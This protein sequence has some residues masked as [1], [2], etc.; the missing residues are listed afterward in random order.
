MTAREIGSIHPRAIPKIVEAIDRCHGTSLENHLHKYILEPLRS[1]NHPQPLII[2]IDAM[3]EWRDHPTFINAL[4]HLN[5]QSHVVKFIITDRLNPC[6]SRLPGI[7]KISIYTYALGP[8]SKQV[9]KAYFHKHLETVPWVDGRTATL[10]D[11][12]KLTELSG[13]LPVW[14]STVIALLSHRFSESPP[15]EVL[16]DIVGSRRQVGGSDGLGELYRKAL[17]RLFPSPE[18][19]RQLLRYLAATIVLQEPLSPFDFSMLSGIPS[20]LINHIQ[21]ALT[22]LQTR[23][24]PLG[25]EEMV[26]PA[27]TLFHQSFLDYVQSTVTGNSFLTSAVDAHSTLGL[28]CLRQLPSLPSSHH[29]SYLRD[30]QGYAVKYWPFHVSKGTP[31]ANDQ[32]SQTEHC[33]TILELTLEVQQRWA[34]LFLESFMPEEMD[35]ITENVGPEDSMVLILTALFDRLRESGEDC[36]VF[37]VAC[38]EVAVRID[39]GDAMVWSHLGNCYKAIG[40]RTGSLHMY[41]EA[42]V[43]FRHALRLQADVHPGRAES[44]HNVANALMCCY[45]QN[46]HR[47]ILNEAISNC[48]E[49]LALRPAPH[50]DRSVSLNNLANAL[51]YL[52]ERDGGIET[53]NNVISLNREALE[54]RPTPHPDRATSLSNLA[55]ALQSLYEC[56]GG[57]RTLNEVVSL[58]REALALRP[59]PHPHRSM[60]LSNLAGALQSLYECDGST[61]TLNEVISRSREALA[62]CPAPHPHRSGLLNTLANALRSLYSQ[63]G[64]VNTLNESVSLHR[65]ALALHPP[66]HP[67]R[68]MSLNNLAFALHSLHECSGGIGTLNEVISLNRE[69]LALCPTPHPYRPM[70]LNNLANA[71]QSLYEC[72]GGIK[73]LSE[74]ISLHR[75]AL[76]LRPAPHPDRSLLLNNLA[77]ALQ[78]LYEHNS[79]VKILT[80]AIALNREALTLYPAT[81]PDRSMSF[82]NLANALQSL[83]KCNGSIKTLNEAISLHHEALALRPAPHPD[84]PQ[85][86]MNLANAFLSQFKQDGALDVLDE[87][88]SHCRELLVLHP[89]GHRYWKSLVEFLVLLLEMRCEKVGDDRDYAE[90]KDL[91][92]ELNAFR[93]ERASR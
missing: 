19:Q 57:S 33:L 67:D 4:A 56:D 9:I 90:V 24:V 69:A 3:D 42:A 51:Q 30:H 1:L 10:V 87:S 85:S 23:S 20:H 52:Y 84:R 14:A 76:A 74:A 72:S 65:E 22:A 45:K 41:E 17:S 70:S 60:S 8:I 59:A 13:G 50:P 44:L 25:S 35:S 79:N 64:D 91:K 83:H 78:S 75:E 2:I 7:E 37:Q 49:A 61:G 62:L 43:V 88:I 53:L 27:S 31:R 26:Y 86:L 36:W 40:H 15:H 63:N 16:E 73:T 48:R 77:G 82:N 28:T 54:L 21:F 6:A 29:A 38:L 93:R 32:W 12:E 68:F 66:P 58:N 18:D 55:S 80:E 81:H 34:T 47:N 92:A 5:P 11:V 89:P 46:G 39:D 71:L